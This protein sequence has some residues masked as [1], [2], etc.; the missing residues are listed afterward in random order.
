MNCVALFCWRG[1]CRCRG[2]IKPACAVCDTGARRQST[3]T[4]RRQHE[5]MEH[6]DDVGSG[7]NDLW[8]EFDGLTTTRDCSSGDRIRRSRLLIHMREKNSTGSAPVQFGVFLKYALLN[9][10][11]VLVAMPASTYYY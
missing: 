2:C 1:C 9:H 10:Y 5:S 4:N 7:D 6:V 11:S 3:P 8:L